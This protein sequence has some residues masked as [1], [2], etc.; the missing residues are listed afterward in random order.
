MEGCPDESTRSELYTR[1][2]DGNEKLVI[3]GALGVKVS[4]PFA[5]P[6]TADA[7]TVAAPS[8]V[9]RMVTV[10]TP[11]LPLVDDAAASVPRLVDHIT[12]T[13]ETRLP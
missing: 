8:V 6:A 12:E 3:V 11:E 9:L 4:A 10:A 13:P 1:V 5:D 2:P 7:V